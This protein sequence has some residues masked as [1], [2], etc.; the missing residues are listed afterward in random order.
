MI[1]SGQMDRSDAINQEEEMLDSIKTIISELL[2]ETIG[3][4]KNEVDEILSLCENI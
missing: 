3:F 4:S 1:N 2:Y